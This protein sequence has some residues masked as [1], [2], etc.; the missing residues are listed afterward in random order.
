MI[1]IIKE[2]TALYLVGMLITLMCIGIVNTHKD[3]LGDLEQLKAI[4][5]FPIFWTKMIITG[6]KELFK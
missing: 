1:D 4:V 3:R 5:F 2:I 6:I